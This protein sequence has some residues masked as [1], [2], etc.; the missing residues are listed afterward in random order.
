MRWE[1]RDLSFMARDEQAQ[2]MTMR[3]MRY[4]KER[5]WRL[6]RI[7]RKDCKTR[8]LFLGRF[9][10]RLYYVVGLMVAKRKV[11][12]LKGLGKRADAF[13]FRKGVRVCFSWRRLCLGLGLIWA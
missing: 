7:E 3:N 13:H 12:T 1:N 6:N 11:P 8:S 9:L 2:I 10:L 5:N 4:R